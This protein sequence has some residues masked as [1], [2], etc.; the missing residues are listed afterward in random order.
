MKNDDV[1]KVVKLTS[2]ALGEITERLQTLV[3]INA[4]VPELAYASGVSM[5]SGCGCKGSCKGGCTSW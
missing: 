1:M 4:D 2:N 5:D 3:A